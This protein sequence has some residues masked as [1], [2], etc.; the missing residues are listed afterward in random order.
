[1]R[2]ADSEF[3][4]FEDAREIAREE[5]AHEITVLRYELT[6]ERWISGQRLERNLHLEQQLAE[7][8]EKIVML[9][10]REEMNVQS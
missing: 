10:H 7:A 3:M 6:H 9:K 4:S 5:F 8:R 2:E 1:M